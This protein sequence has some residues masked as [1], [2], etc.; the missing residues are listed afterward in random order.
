[1]E[2]F[3]PFSTEER[4]DVKLLAKLILAIGLQTKRESIHG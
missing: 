1:M 3:G 2:Q 4:S